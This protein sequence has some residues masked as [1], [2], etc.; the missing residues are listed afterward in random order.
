LWECRY[1]SLVVVL[2]ISSSLFFFIVVFH[3]SSVGGCSSRGISA[4]SPV[5][6]FLS[7]FC[8]ISFGG[9]VF[10]G[11]YPVGVDINGCREIVDAG[12][13]ALSAN[14]AVKIAHAALLVELHRDGLLVIAEEACEGGGENL[15]LR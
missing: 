9:D 11:I 3:T 1:G 7:G 2:F 5:S 13:E 4:G 14:F 6:S 15:A 10:T 8:L 12:L